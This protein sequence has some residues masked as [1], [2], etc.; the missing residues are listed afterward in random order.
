V[1]LQIEGDLLR[2]NINADW[3]DIKEKLKH[4]KRTYKKAKPSWP[5]MN[6]MKLSYEGDLLIS[7]LYKIP[8]SQKIKF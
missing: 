4:L 1:W 8:F 3:E 7:T 2:K 5:F 6:A